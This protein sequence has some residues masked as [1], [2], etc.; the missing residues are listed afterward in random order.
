MWLDKQLMFSEDQTM[1]S[2]TA[3]A[4]KT[5]TNVIDLGEAK[6]G[7]GNPVGIFVEFNTAPVLTITTTATSTMQIQLVTSASEAFTTSSTLLD[8]GAIPAFST[9]TA[10]IQYWSAIGDGPEWN[11]LPDGT[12]Q[13]LRVIYTMG[14]GAIMTAGAISAGLVLGK[15][16]NV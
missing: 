15:Q 2:A 10:G 12:K 9:S 16:S 1:I 7:E 3:S 8:T 13:Y 5:S 11:F 6:K 4:V 14:A